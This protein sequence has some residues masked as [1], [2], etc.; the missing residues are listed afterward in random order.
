MKKEDKKMIKVVVGIPTLG[1]VEYD[2]IS[3]IS[4]LQKHDIRLEVKKESSR[5]ISIS[6]NLIVKHFLNTDA[7][8]LFFV[9]SDISLPDNA[10]QLFE[11]DKD[12]IS[13]FYP[14]W[15]MNTMVPCLLRENTPDNLSFLARW[16][17]D[18]L[19]Q[20]DAAGAGC[21]LIK[22]KVLEKI[23]PPWFDIEFDEERIG[24]E[25]GEDI[26]FCRNAK[27]YG[28]EI[29]GDTGVR[30][31]HQKSV[32]LM[33][34]YEIL[35]MNQFSQHQ[36]AK[37]LDIKFKDIRKIYEDYIFTVSP[38]NW[39]LSWEGSC[40]IEKLIKSL[41]PKRILDFGSGWT[42]FVTRQSY[43][44][45]WS[46]D[47]SQEWLDKTRAFLEK[48]NTRTDNLILYDDLELEGKFDI[49]ILDI[50]PAK[51]RHK[52][53]DELREHCSGVILIDDMQFAEYRKEIEEY[54]KNDLVFDLFEETLDRYGRHLWM[55]VIK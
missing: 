25:H 5:P 33:R 4:K 51:D 41:H 2:T 3:T 17:W 20:Y 34:I 48:H 31:G 13:G 14:L 23:P 10:F 11:A 53:L 29:W 37:Q 12:I 27:K 8:Y 55:V 47:T 26:W 7:D 1:R 32:D 24:I 21:L 52:Y 50:G 42:S 40:Y 54:F 15:V 44:E 45:V 38:E 36:F 43:A 28:F 19:E 16:K 18:T 9:D 22:R 39:A 49:I 46:V 35:H 30:C 6:R